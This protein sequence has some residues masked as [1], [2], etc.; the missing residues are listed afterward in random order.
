MLPSSLFALHTPSTLAEPRL[1]A[2]YRLWLKEG[3][4]TVSSQSGVSEE[5]NDL[6]PSSIETQLFIDNEFVP[7]QSGKTFDVINPATEKVSAS[8]SEADAADVDSAVRA[9]KFAFP[10]WSALSGFERAKYFF[11]LADI[12]EKSNMEL[13][14]LEAICMGK[15]VGKY[16]KSRSILSRYTFGELTVSSRGHQHLQIY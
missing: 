4:M 2:P 10:S 16:S 13:A 15:P 14:R 12:I 8:V 1:L 9:A 5:V 6:H 3:N 11:R 7:S